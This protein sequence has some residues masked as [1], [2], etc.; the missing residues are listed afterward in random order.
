M[1]FVVNEVIGEGFIGLWVAFTKTSVRE[2][3]EKYD[4]DICV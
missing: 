2:V 3:C 4:L 1:V